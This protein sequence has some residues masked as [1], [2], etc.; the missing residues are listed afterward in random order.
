MTTTRI[1]DVR[2]A[3]HA[4]AGQQQETVT[5]ANVCL[6]RIAGASCV[7]VFSYVPKVGG[8]FVVE[9]GVAGTGPRGFGKTVA[10]TLRAAAQPVGDAM[11]RQETGREVG[12]S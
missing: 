9:V 1:V 12:L 11:T 6:D 2:H 3:D 8:G 7:V 5:G 4:E 10:D